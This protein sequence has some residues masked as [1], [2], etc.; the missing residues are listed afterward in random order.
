MIILCAMTQG[1]NNSY[2]QDLLGSSLFF[3]KPK[4]SEAE[5]LLLSRRLAGQ[6]PAGW[7]LPGGACAWAAR[8]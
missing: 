1:C 7:R 6:R 4:S 2:D 5:A 8:H 3:P